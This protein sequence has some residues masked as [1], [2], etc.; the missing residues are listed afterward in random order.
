MLMIDGQTGGRLLAIMHGFE[1]WSDD[2][3]VLG[4][5]AAIEAWAERS[6]VPDGSVPIC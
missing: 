2:R 4:V 1:R 6:E 3:K 5:R